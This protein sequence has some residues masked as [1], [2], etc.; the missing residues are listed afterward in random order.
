MSW[1]EALLLGVIQGLTEF[2]PVSSDGHLSAA[3]LLLPRFHQVGVLF[4]V[5][6]HVGT[7]AAVVV[8]FRKALAED[9]A[10][11]FS[12]DAS[13]RSASW[14]LTALVVAATVPTGIVGLL[15]KTTVETSKRDPRFVGAM[16]ILTAL[17][18]TLSLFARK[19]GR[20]RSQTTLWDALLIGTVQGLAVLPGLSRSATTIAF[21]LLVGLGTEWAAKFSFYLLIPAVLGATILEIFAAGEEQGSAFF[22][23]SDFAKYLFGAAVAG[24]VGYF[25]IGWLIR[26]VV[27]RRLFWF[28]LYC[29][30]FGLA[31]I[32]LFP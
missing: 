17:F 4:D 21:A 19:T 31:L 18:L 16:E 26:A 13:R 3:E 11:L 9:V 1:A 5:M 20:D 32:Y 28:A 30:L 12:A 27:A 14:R 29:V 25:A 24:I 2:L 10:G 6:V 23:G 8:Y 15:L 7:L 22:A